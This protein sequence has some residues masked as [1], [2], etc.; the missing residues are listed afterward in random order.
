MKVF[1]GALL[2]ACTLASAQSASPAPAFDVASI[3]PTDPDYRGGTIS[4]SPGT[5]IMRGVSLR[6]CVE[7]A[8]NIRPYQITGPAWLPDI[9][10]DISAKAADPV[11][12]DQL[13]LMLQTLLANRF[14]MKV[15]RETRKLPAFSLVVAPGGP[16]FHDTGSGNASKFVESTKDGDANFTEDR[17]GLIAERATMAD[18][19]AKLAEPLQRPVVDKTN[20]KGRYDIRIDLLPFLNQVGAYEEN[21][22]NLD[23]ISVIVTAF[24]N[25]LGLKL[26]PTKENVDFVIVDSASKTPTEN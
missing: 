12:I 2:A 24:P 5:L 4:D 20:L 19:T 13:R 9:R 14:G 6:T 25:Q 11:G 21:K 16:K 7:W 17:T 22:A 10:F 26:E 1:L 15:H 3:R 18:L 8:Y 23:V